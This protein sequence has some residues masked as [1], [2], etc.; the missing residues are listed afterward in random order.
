MHFPSN[1]DTIP[2]KCRTK[3]AQ[4]GLEN[5]QPKASK[6]D[7]GKA[8][9]C[10]NTDKFAMTRLPAPELILSIQQGQSAPDA[11]ALR[12][13]HTRGKRESSPYCTKRPG[14]LEYSGHYVREPK[15]KNTSRS[16][17]VR[18]ASSASLPQRSSNDPS[19]PLSSPYTRALD[20]MAPCMISPTK[21]SLIVCIHAYHSIRRLSSYV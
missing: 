10:A 17:S 4:N 12:A 9:T 21:P 15:A 14:S 18:H 3:K 7:I 20:S 11:N 1:A 2:T 16:R 6:R 19:S 13:S 5:Y 8:P